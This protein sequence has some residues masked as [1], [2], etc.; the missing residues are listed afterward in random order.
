MLGIN[1]TDCLERQVYLA[2]RGEIIVRFVFTTLSKPLERSYSDHWR[3]RI[4]S[5][6]YEGIETLQFLYLRACVRLTMAL[7]RQKVRLVVLLEEIEDI[8]HRLRAGV[9][10]VP[11][12][13]IHRHW[14]RLVLDPES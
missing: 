12:G 5:E 3:A 7:H 6:M 14:T 9:P 8:H 4:S 2:S 1:C 10:A 13:W 11:R